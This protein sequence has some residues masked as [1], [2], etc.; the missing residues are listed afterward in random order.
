MSNLVIDIPQEFLRQIIREE[1]AL[2]LNGF[3]EELLEH[4]HKPEY[5]QWGRYLN[6]DQTAKYLSVGKSGLKRRLALKGIHPIVFNQREKVF[7]RYELDKLNV[8]QFI[9]SYKSRIT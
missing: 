1:L 9:E 7:D 3:A 4:I 5:E 8:N 6:Y 2:E